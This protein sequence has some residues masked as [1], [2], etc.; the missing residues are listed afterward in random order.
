M[1]AIAEEAKRATKMEAGDLAI[2]VVGKQVRI[3]EI[4]G[5]SK[6]KSLAYSDTFQRDRFLFMHVP[7][8]EMVRA[9]DF[10]VARLYRKP[11]NARKVIAKYFPEYARG[12]ATA[13]LYYAGAGPRGRSLLTGEGYFSVLLS[14]AAESIDEARAFG[15]PG[16][17]G[18]KAHHWFMVGHAAG[19]MGKPFPRITT[20]LSVA[21]VKAL[22][23]GYEKGVADREKKESVDE[24]KV[25]VIHGTQG[26]ALM[27]MPV[28][29]TPYWWTGTKW[30]DKKNEV[31]YYEKAGAKSE[32]GNARAAAQKLVRKLKESIDEAKK[33]DPAKY[34]GPKYKIGDRV[35]IVRRFGWKK[36]HK[37]V[38][39]KPPVPG[40]VKQVDRNILHPK[41]PP[42]LTLEID[43]EDYERA[44]PRVA[45]TKYHRIRV[46]SDE[47]EP[48]KG[49]RGESMNERYDPQAARDY[50]LA[51]KDRKRKA[52]AREY[53]KA[54]KGIRMPPSPEEFKI[55]TQAAR[56]VEQ[57]FKKIGAPLAASVQRNDPTFEQVARIVRR[58]KCAGFNPSRISLAER[59]MPTTD[60][61]YIFLIHHETDETYSVAHSV[62]DDPRLGYQELQTK[63]DKRAAEKIGKADKKKV[64][65]HPKFVSEFLV[66]MTQYK[67]ALIQLIRCAEE[68]PLAPETE[69]FILN[70]HEQLVELM[71]DL[72]EL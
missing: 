16:N 54:I 14:G 12:G 41:G 71:R 40:K 38:P 2:E 23:K 67:A 68:V 6:L 15:L 46:K 43:P 25:Q 33:F 37:P 8:E 17:K 58:A 44:S 27:F 55:T 49:G 11:E 66:V 10:T 52:Y 7:Q 19:F 30:S 31:R 70:R 26:S 32:L 5:G 53:L 18:A 51:I 1:P 64:R 21:N 36:G 9:K 45:P 63:L 20:V 61:D 34:T 28:P 50:V 59:A 35:Q 22:K 39:I 60:V 72:E 13:H 69:Q 57:G 4:T 56:E 42:E 3:Y 62:H 48:L 47:V 29:L 24:A 65:E